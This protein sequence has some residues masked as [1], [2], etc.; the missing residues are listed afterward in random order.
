MNTLPQLSGRDYLVED[1]VK[2]IQKRSKQAQN[3]KK[4]QRAVCYESGVS[5]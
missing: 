1:L 5:P 3:G 4:A 2:C